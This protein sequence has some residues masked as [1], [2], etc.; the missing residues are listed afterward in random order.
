MLVVELE[1]W[2]GGDMNFIISFNLQEKF[3][4]QFDL[5]EIIHTRLFPTRL[6]IDRA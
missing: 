6:D 1:R 2:R 5:L 4:L 3:Y